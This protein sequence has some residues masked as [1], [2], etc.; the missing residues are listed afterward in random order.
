MN[1]LEL[2]YGTARRDAE[3]PNFYT[4]PVFHSFIGAKPYL[5]ASP[6]VQELAGKP[7]ASTQECVYALLVKQGYA[8]KKL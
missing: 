6:S 3:L 1:L 2:E 5:G 4:H 8:P 7:G